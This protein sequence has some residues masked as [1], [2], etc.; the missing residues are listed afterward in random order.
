MRLSGNIFVLDYAID[1]INLF[2]IGLNFF[3]MVYKKPVEDGK[4]SKNKIKFHEFQLR[5]MV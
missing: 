4:D 5:R 3:T 2:D 1:F